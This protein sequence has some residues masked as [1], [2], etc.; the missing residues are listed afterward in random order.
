MHALDDN[1]ENRAVCGP[2]AARENEAY[3]D[4]LGSLRVK[5]SLWK[6][7]MSL[8]TPFLLE[9]MLTISHGAEATQI[10]DLNV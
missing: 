7:G 2:L 8:N 9:T 3:L 10:L 1:V 4:H 6:P 5:W